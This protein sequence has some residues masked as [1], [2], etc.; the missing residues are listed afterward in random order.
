MHVAKHMRAVKVSLLTHIS[1]NA[2]E[3]LLLVS[4]IATTT[5]LPLL[6]MYD[7][8]FPLADEAVQKLPCFV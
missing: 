8:W 4:G 1:M 5:T 6:W 2:T 7:M 3:S